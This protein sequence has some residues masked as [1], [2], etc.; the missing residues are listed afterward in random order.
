[1]IA[2]KGLVPEYHKPVIISQEQRSCLNRSNSENDN[3][4]SLIPK[5]YAANRAPAN[6]EVYQPYLNKT[7]QSGYINVLIT[8]VRINK[9]NKYVSKPTNKN[10][11]NE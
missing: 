2:V 3:K 4:K 8:L 10:L 11:M 6:P 5:L 7:I 9:M 1:M